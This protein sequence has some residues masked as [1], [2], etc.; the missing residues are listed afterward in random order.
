[1]LAGRTG[2]A[3]RAGRAGP[4]ELDRAAG[5]GGWLA[6]DG[7]AAGPDDGWLAVDGFGGWAGRVAG[8]GP[9]NGSDACPYPG[10]GLAGRI[11]WILHRPLTCTSTSLSRCWS[12]APASAT[13]APAASRS[14]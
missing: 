5:P 13:M 7:F 12:A 1:M 4:A 14:W 6:V 10:A 3:A 8:N 9:G 11:S 2:R